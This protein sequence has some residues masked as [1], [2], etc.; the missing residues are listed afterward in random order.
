MSSILLGHA[1]PFVAS[2]ENGAD[3]PTLGEAIQQL[4]TSKRQLGRRERYVKA[5]GA[6]LS[7][8]AR[9]R[10]SVPVAQLSP[11]HVENWL[12]AR[13]DKPST[14]QSNLSRLSTLFSFCER[15]RY[16][17]ENFCD[18]IETPSQDRMP[19]QV[20]TV[21]QAESALKFTLD[22]KPEFLAWLALTLLLGLRPESEADKLEHGRIDLENHRLIVVVSKVRSHR[23]I[24]LADIPPAEPWL[25]KA[26]EVK[27]RF[28]IPYATRRRYIRALREHLGFD[29]WPQDLL[30][31]SAASYLLA[32]HQSAERVAMILGNSP[33]VLHRHY[34]SLVTSGDAQLFMALRP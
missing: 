28:Q 22:Q 18:R 26:I 16:I 13:N 4:L 17:K 34:K 24:H 32:H 29:R 21:E 12:M 5:L 15:R 25:K 11:E 33:G 3:T 1:S 9:G 20:L 19:P 30:R 2:N 14:K 31:H 10:E 6:A 7:V 23:I 8:F 27:A